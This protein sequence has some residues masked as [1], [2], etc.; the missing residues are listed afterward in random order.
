[1]QKNKSI[2]LL[3]NGYLS[4]GIVN[5][6][7]GDIIC[8]NTELIPELSKISSPDSWSGLLVFF[9]DY[10]FLSIITAL[11][12]RSFCSDH[13]FNIMVSAKLEKPDSVRTF[14]DKIM[15]WSIYQDIQ[16]QH[17]S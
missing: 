4:G 10:L 5:H 17:F 8:L 13:R 16:E 11:Y 1:M 7:D 12:V 14:A 9:M 6:D 2:R 15:P 3:A